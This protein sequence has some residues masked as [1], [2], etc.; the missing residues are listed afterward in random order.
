VLKAL[1]L[2]LQLKRVDGLDERLG[3]ELT[4]MAE[5]YTAER[6]AAGRPIPKDLNKL[7]P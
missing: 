5:D 3:P 4:R 1:S 6:R 7:L 2:G